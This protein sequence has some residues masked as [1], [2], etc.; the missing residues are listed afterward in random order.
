MSNPQ[1]QVRFLADDFGMHTSIDVAVLDLAA[2]GHLQGA[3][4]LVGSPNFDLGRLDQLQVHG[5]WTGI[6][7]AL[8][9]VYPVRTDLFDAPWVDAQGRFIPNWKRLIGPLLRK[10][11]PQAKVYDEWCAQVDKLLAYVDEIHYIDSHQNLHLLPQFADIAR[12]VQQRYNIPYIRVFYD[13]VRLTRPLYGL[14]AKLGDRLYPRPMHLPTYGL[15][16]SGNLEASE[17]KRTIQGARRQHR[18]FAVMCHPGTG[19]LDQFPDKLGVDY[20]LAWK[21][22]YD[23]L[24][25]NDLADW[26]STQNIT[27]ATEDP[28]FLAPPLA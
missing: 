27:R 19:R 16:Q 8:T 23:L 21:Q 25:S 17:L 5:V 7:L 14:I 20:E 28:A 13:G 24:R 9:D 22:E 11:L 3:S 6:H 10:R 15:Y 1:T 18:D 4:I 2:Q 26:L 12:A